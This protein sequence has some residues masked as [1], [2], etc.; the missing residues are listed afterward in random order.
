MPKPGRRRPGGSPQA[1]W[2]RR[3]NSS[4]SGGVRAAAAGRPAAP[5]ATQPPGLADCR[6]RL[7]Q[8]ICPGHSIPWFPQGLA[9]IC[10]TPTWRKSKPHAGGRDTMAADA[11][12][13]IEG[14]WPGHRSGERT[15]CR[16]H[17]GIDRGAGR[18][19]RPCRLRASRSLPRAG[20][21]AEPLRKACEEAVKTLPGVLSVTAVLTAHQRA[22]ECATPVMP[23]IRMQQ[24]QQ[25]PA[26][27]AGVATDHRGGERQR[28]RRQIDRGGESGARSR[29]AG[30]ESRACWMPISTGRACRACSTSA[31][32]RRAMARS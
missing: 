14:A 17:A 3:S 24:P 6:F 26:G 18:A 10:A 5:W 4:R 8:A 15:G 16:R 32:S 27:I 20:R 12:R 22:A 28:R 11:R 23:D 9:V 1:S 31:R 19:R 25:A 2:P 29:A 7:F 13:R 30:P 21:D